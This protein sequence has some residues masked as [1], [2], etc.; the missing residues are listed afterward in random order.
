MDKKPYIQNS[1]SVKFDSMKKKF[2]RIFLYAC[3]IWCITLVITPISSTQLTDNIWAS[4]APMQEP[5]GRLGVEAVNG[6][7]YA[8]GGSTLNIIGPIVGPYRYDIGAGV[9]TTEEYNLSTDT[10]IYKTPMPTPRVNF[11]IA[12]C[13]GK[14]YCLGG[15]SYYNETNANEVYDP[16]TDS[17]ETRAPLPIPTGATTANVVG[18]KIYLVSTKWSDN[19]LTQVYDPLTDSWTT[20]TSPPT[21][22]GSKASAVINDKI[23]FVNKD[24]FIQIYDPLNDRWSTGAKAPSAIP[25]SALYPLES[26]TAVATT[27]E[28]APKRI[29][30]LSE[31]GN[32]IYNPIDDTWATGA[33]DP[34]A[35]GYAG[36]VAINDIVYNV[37]GMIFEISAGHMG[38]TAV[39]EQYTPI[40]YGTVRPADASTWIVYATGIVATMAVASGIIVYSKK[41]HRCSA[42]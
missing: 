31:N 29:Y 35:R 11:G 36:A 16:A 8:I 19:N 6:K 27:G 13:G 18:D 2:V 26:A 4:K 20:K 32:Y 30:F 15:S 21:E 3:A 40:G 5:R 39:N 28:H 25:F 24:G 14:I 34:T 12:V 38:P 1:K 17:W 37:G 10:W 33:D 7:I 41:H 42:S 22:I 9:G 23:F